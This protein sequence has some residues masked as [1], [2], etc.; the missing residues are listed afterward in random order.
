MN[1]VRTWTKEELENITNLLILEARLE[2][3]GV[4]RGLSHRQVSN[5]ASR[6]VQLEGFSNEIEVEVGK[7][8][9]GENNT[10]TC[11]CCEEGWDISLE[12]KAA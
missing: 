11:S 2:R 5:V 6:I 10:Y 9:N 3:R 7:C 8:P 1:K 4:F 12:K